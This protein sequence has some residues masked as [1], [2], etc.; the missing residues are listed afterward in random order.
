MVH[1]VYIVYIHLLYDTYINILLAYQYNS[2]NVDFWQM[3][4][5]EKYFRKDQSLTTA[6]DPAA[7]RDLFNENLGNPSDN[8]LM[9]IDL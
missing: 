8:L 7:V 6:G 1:V 3:G 2:R 5:A 4:P 9:A